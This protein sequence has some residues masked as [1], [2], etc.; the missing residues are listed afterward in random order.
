MSASEMMML[1]EELAELRAEVERL[2]AES[3]EREERTARIMIEAGRQG[4]TPLH[5]LRSRPLHP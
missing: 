3:L 2:R 5:A 1:E 4:P